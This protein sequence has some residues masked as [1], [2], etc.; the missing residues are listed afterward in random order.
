MNLFANLLT[1]EGGVKAVVDDQ[2]MELLEEVGLKAIDGN[3]VVTYAFAPK[4]PSA[5]EGASS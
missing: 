3:Q 5:S 4:Q 2:T 1:G